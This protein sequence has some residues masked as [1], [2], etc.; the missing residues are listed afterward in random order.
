MN[1]YQYIINPVTNRKVLINTQIGTRI[2]Q[3]YLLQVGGTNPHTGK[4]WS[5]YS[6]KGLT[7]NK[8]NSENNKK[9]CNWVKSNSKRKGHCKKRQH[10]SRK[11]AKRNWKNLKSK[12][13]PIYK[14]LASAKKVLED[15]EIVEYNEEY[16]VVVLA[17]EY[18]QYLDQDDYIYYNRILEKAGLEIYP[19]YINMYDDETDFTLEVLFIVEPI[20]DDDERY[21]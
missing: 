1:T 2:L 12:I 3:K 13:T 5:S 20:S 10:S 4:K 19:E 7:R 11:R 16:N 21:Q 6:C 14:I 17:K 18:L 9:R 15:D 8:C